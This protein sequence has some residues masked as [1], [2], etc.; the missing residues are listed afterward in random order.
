MATANTYITDE[1]YNALVDALTALDRDPAH[2]QPLSDRT[3]ATLGEIGGVWPA[4]IHP[5]A[6]DQNAKTPADKR[7]IER[8]RDIKDTN[9]KAV[10]MLDRIKPP[11]IGA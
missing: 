6:L 8:Y 7:A 5:D 4:S 11:K 1:A 2:P 3:I 9:A 10:A